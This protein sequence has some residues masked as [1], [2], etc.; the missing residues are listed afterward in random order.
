MTPAVHASAS[1]K[2]K[3]PSIPSVGIS[4]P[5]NQDSMVY[6][7]STP[8]RATNATAAFKYPPLP[9]DDDEWVQG[10]DKKPPAQHQSE[11]KTTAFFSDEP[12][13]DTSNYKI[14][15]SKKDSSPKMEDFLKI[16]LPSDGDLPSDDEEWVLDDDN[17]VPP[18]ANPAASP[19]DDKKPSAKAAPHSPGLGP[20]LGKEKL[21][22]VPPL[23][24]DNYGSI[25]EL[26]AGQHGL[27]DSAQ[28]KQVFAKFQPVHLLDKN[29]ETEFVFA[30][31]KEAHVNPRGDGF[32]YDV[33]FEKEGE[34]SQDSGHPAN[35]HEM[36]EVPGHRLANF[37]F[38]G[39]E[40]LETAR[41]DVTMQ[42]FKWEKVIIEK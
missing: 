23:E 9:P 8:D 41:N 39:A 32:S 4:T 29:G 21:F 1:T 3:N 24:L 12:T 22:V 36:E 42:I 28:D 18:N 37:E 40:S 33:V 10:G 2:K 11:G 26:V 30:Y 16:P 31:V 19:L 7:L 38:E 27:E 35:W 25:E 13:I 5:S 34:P 15:P 6:T 14:S 20:E 17:G